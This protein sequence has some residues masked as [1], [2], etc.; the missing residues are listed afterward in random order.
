[1][2][3]YLEKPVSNPKKEISV[4]AISFK[5]G[6]IVDEKSNPKTYADYL[7]DQS[8]LPAAKR[9]TE[10]EQKLVKQ[11]YSVGEEYG[12]SEE[13]VK[14]LADILL[15][16]L[17]TI[18]FIALPL[19]AFILQ[20]VFIRRKGFYYMHHGIFVLHVATSLFLVLWLTNVVDLTALA[21]HQNWLHVASSI[22]V[23]AWIVY[24]FV[25]FKRF[26][27]LSRGKAVA[28]FLTA[29]FLQNIVLL[30]IFLGL[31]VFSFFSL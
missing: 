3:S 22:L 8:K 2:E 25:S 14:A 21:F 23:W 29:T 7:K 24:Y 11:A 17:S 13:L 15:H 20:L 31:L 26:Y 4:P 5:N 10:W 18:L 27:R 30:I 9:D 19:L 1:L 6:L 28:Y 12:N 16:K